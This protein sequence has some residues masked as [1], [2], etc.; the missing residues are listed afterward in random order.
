MKTV[1]TGGIVVSSYGCRRLDVLVED[2]KIAALGNDLDATAARIVDAAGCYLLPGFID[3]HTHLEL[4]NGRADTADNFTTGSI[5]A[6]CKGTTTVI[7]MATPERSHTLK[8]CLAKWNRMAEG[9]SSC[10]YNYHMSLIEFN[11]AVAK[12]IPEMV[13]AGVTSFKMYMAYDNLRTTDA[14][15]YEAMKA[16]QKV[17]GML[18]VHCENGDL[19]NALQAQF[20][21]EGKTAPKYHPLS[22]PNALEAEA[23]NRYLMIANE[24][25][26]AVNIV[27]LSTREALEVVLRARKN[28]QKVFVETCPQYLLLDDH[29]YDSPDFEGAKYVCAPPLRSIQD[30]QALWQGVIHGAIDTISTDHCDFNFASQKT[31][32]KNDFTQIP[33]G[34]PGVETRAELL[35]TA[36]VATGKIS[37]EQFVALL[38]ENIAR[39]FHLY[40]QKGVLAVGS[41]ADIVLWDPNA[42]G[43]ITA[44]TQLQNVDYSAYEG[45]Q[46]VGA[47]KAVY[48][49][50]QAI[51]ENGRL[52]RGQQGKFV[53]RKIPKGK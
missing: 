22:R 8:E 34:L 53:F 41:D 3:A 46:T 5:A 23:V 7:D 33:G 14:E 16:I 35:Y 10:D 39:Q 30:Q 9:K 51:S 13:A 12:E 18:G 27:H 11:E 48:L 36:G 45:F 26:L 31:L 47:A 40:P 52:L 4:N 25:G 19:V 24:A 32:G 44:Q 42:N 1:F 6:V 43:V 37:I 28:G 17:G 15:L 21:R 50:G 38:S 20:L 29:L 49:R 2:E